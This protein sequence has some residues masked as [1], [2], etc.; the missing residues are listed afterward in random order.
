[1]WIYHCHILAV[2]RLVK[3]M[4]ELAF[5]VAHAL[6]PIDECIFRTAEI[7]PAEDATLMVLVLRTISFTFNQLR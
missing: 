7:V 4:I 5:P 2:D 1:M 3:G 6:L